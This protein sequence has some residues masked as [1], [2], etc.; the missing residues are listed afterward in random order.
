MTNE[1]LETMKADAKKVVSDLENIMSHVKAD[2]KA[3]VGK[4]KARFGHDNE[5][6]KKA[7]YAKADIKADAEKAKADVENRM[8]H[9]KADAEKAK[10]E[11]AELRVKIESE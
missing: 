1:N 7:A 10:S 5:V 11:K 3:D 9:A 4:V 2:A 6:G 8:A